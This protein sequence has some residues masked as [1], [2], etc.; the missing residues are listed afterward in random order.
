MDLRSLIEKLD[1]IEQSKLLLESE[2]LMEKV[3]IRYSD[4]EAVAKQYATDDDARGQALAKLA[5]DN[6]LKTLFDPV[7]GELVNADGSYSTFKGADEATVERLKSWG[8]LPLNAK[9]S[10]WL[11]FRGQDRK[12]AIGDNQTAQGR[13]QM[14]DRAEE[15]MKKAVTI[16]S[17]A[18]VAKESIAESLLSSFGYTT[19]LLEYVTPEEHTELKGLVQKL[20]PFAKQDPDAADIVARF[21]AYNEKRN[22]LIARIKE[23]IAAIKPAAASTPPASVPSGERSGSSA[24]KESSENND[25]NILLELS[26]TPQG[27][28]AGAKLFEP[29]ATGY[30][31]PKQVQHN[32]ALLKKG[33]A[34]L[35]WNDHVGKTVKDWANMATF[36]LADKAAAYASSV[37]D[38]NTS[39]EKE[40]AK[41]KAIDQA[42]DQ[43]PNALNVR[44]AANAVGYKMDPTNPVGNITVGDVLG[45][46]GPGAANAMFR[47]GLKGVALVGGKKVSQTVGGL[48]AILAGN[49]L[50]NQIGKD[51]ESAEP[52]TDKPAP[53]PNNPV[54]PQPVENLKFDPEVKKIQDYL[55]TAYGGAKSILPRFGSDGKLGKETIA[56][57]E[58]AKK[59][60]KL[61]PDGKVPGTTT[62]DTKTDTN[63]SAALDP[64]LVQDE[65]KKL[66]IT[67]NQITPE[68]LIALADS[69]GIKDTDSSASADTV[70][71][72]SDTTGVSAKPTMALNTTPS[73][74]GGIVQGTTATTESME[75]SRILAL[76]GAD[77]EEGAFDRI[78]SWVIDDMIVKGMS[79]EAALASQIP[80]A[81]MSAAEREAIRAAKALAKRIEAQGKPA[82]VGA[83]KAVVGA[84][85][86]VPKVADDAV[87][88]LTTD[89]AKGQGLLYNVGKLGG[90]FVRLVKN[91]K[92]LS[93]L[94]VLAALGIGLYL[95]N[96]DDSKPNDGPGGPGGPGVTPQPAVDPQAEE[97]KRQLLD[98]EKLLAQLYGGWP[99]DAETA[100][101]I[102]AAVAAGAKAPEG[103]TQSGVNTQP[104]NSGKSSGAGL[105]QGQEAG[106]SAEELIRLRNEKLKSQKP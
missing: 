67:G 12:T 106:A 79:R 90:R 36:G 29:S 23:I 9:T 47:V 15:L 7:S 87:A 33:H 86:V 45:L 30:L 25:S 16:G 104:A 92:F 26:L 31:D 75:L 72:S 51:P 37:G 34:K 101:T 54:Q 55:V 81:G 96:K 14:V 70:T 64:K 97:R 41:Q 66:G 39:Y 49:A 74:D 4:V 73:S 46:V 89:A 100:E 84:E 53:G 102:K 22:D 82:V 93:I 57:I 94:A 68:Q 2:Q 59:E 32:L 76:S 77:L 58:R 99:T 19:T 8:L 56:A 20:T 1:T 65:L 6:G 35:D 27:Q 10:S 28:K 38:K 17:A 21:N 103:F 13:D 80:K 88:K 69:L 61:T 105:W 60:G 44:T 11:G 5:K 83:E 71:S 91:N 52:T 3:R 62:A 78:A 63:T 40:R 43:D 24:K 95:A 98:L 50:A 85:K 42:Y 18:P 48:G